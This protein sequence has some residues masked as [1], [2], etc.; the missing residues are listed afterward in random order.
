MDI[1]NTGEIAGKEVVQ[2]YARDHFASISPPLRKLV[3]YNKVA[4][5][6]GETITISFNVSFEE[7]GFYNYDN[8]WVNEP[9]KHSFYID[10]LQATFNLK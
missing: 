1:K 4:L 9:G 3:R 10:T 6:A 8:I 7:L 5:G 2:L